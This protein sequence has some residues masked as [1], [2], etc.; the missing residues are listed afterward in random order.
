MPRM[1]NQMH[2]ED[3][4]GNIEFIL[5]SVGFYLP[6]GHYVECMLLDQIIGL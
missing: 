6:M 4:L 1:C 2:D 3:E 5:L